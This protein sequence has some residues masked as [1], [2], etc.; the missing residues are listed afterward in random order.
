MMTEGRRPWRT[1]VGCLVDTLKH[2]IGTTASRLRA[3]VPQT[4][5]RP[6]SFALNADS[7][8]A[9]REQVAERFL[10][11]DRIDKGGIVVSCRVD[12]TGDPVADQASF[13][14]G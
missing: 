2:P 12:P 4:P 7:V 10:V 5:R 6:G 9:V 3:H 11:R 8:F 1:A 14:T 13:G